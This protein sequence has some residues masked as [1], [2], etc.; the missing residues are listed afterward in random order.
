MT[1]PGR[2]R[3]K[4]VR[5]RRR[6]RQVTA[7]AWA[8]DHEHSH[9]QDPRSPEGSQRRN[10]CGGMSGSARTAITNPTQLP[11]TSAASSAVRAAYPPVHNRAVVRSSDTP[12]ARRRGSARACWLPR[13]CLTVTARSPIRDGAAGSICALSRP[14][15]SAAAR[16]P[17]RRRA[18]PRC[19]CIARVRRA[20][21]E[22]MLLSNLPTM[23]S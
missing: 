9:D 16:R 14:V 12:R 1:S 3:S 19:W 11:P 6:T 15:G 22:V 18:L 23:R 13:G 21:A 5:E 8:S 2:S 17:R 4:A 7:T 20:I 10:V